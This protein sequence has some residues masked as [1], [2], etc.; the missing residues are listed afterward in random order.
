VI[1]IRSPGSVA[2]AIEM[3]DAVASRSRQTVSR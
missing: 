1:T 3:V 2:A